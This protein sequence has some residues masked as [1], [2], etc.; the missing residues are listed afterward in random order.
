[1]KKVLLLA[2]IFIMAIVTGCKKEFKQ[3]ENLPVITFISPVQGGVYT[4]GDT[5]PIKASFSDD[6]KVQAIS[7][8]VNRQLP[9]SSIFNCA[10]A[11]NNKTAVLD[12]FM[13]IPLS[14]YGNYQFDLYCQDPYN[15]FTIQSIT[16]T[17]NVP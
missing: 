15:N 12:T 10:K 14:L 13:V 7:A 1:M 2:P 3:E 6:T 8:D 9:V 17:A 16:F 4:T 5:V 11:Y